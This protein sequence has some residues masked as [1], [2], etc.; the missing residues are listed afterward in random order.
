[1]HIV[2]GILGWVVVNHQGHSL[3]IQPSS[4]HVRRTNNL[5]VTV[6]EIIQSTL[7]LFLLLV[8]MNGVAAH[9]RSVQSVLKLLAGL[10]RV[11]EDH[12]TIL[13]TALLRDVILQE[14]LRQVTY[15]LVRVDNLDDLFDGIRSFQVLCA[16]DLDLEGVVHEFGSYLLH[17]RVPR[18]CEEEGLPFCFLLYL[19][20]R[21]AN[22]RFETHVEHPV[23]FVHNQL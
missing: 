3:D 9:P 6:P 5:C 14:E 4:S 20:D 10:L 12:R 17:V 22:L 8:A 19:P 16:A 15:L 1:M 11:A 7:T 2:F 18:C 21:L 23:G 13:A